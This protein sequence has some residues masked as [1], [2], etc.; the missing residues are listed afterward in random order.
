MGQPFGYDEDQAFKTIQVE[1]SCA[2]CKHADTRRESV[3]EYLRSRGISQ[4]T[5]AHG[6]G[7]PG[8]NTIARDFK[9]G[10]IVPALEHIALCRRP[11]LGAGT[12]MVMLAYCCAGW[13]ED[14]GRVFV[15]VGTAVPSAK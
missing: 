5:D 3:I 2:N 4:V 12:E 14:K 9:W 1:C 13:Q 6:A 11:E 15:P 7:I 10:D 8:E